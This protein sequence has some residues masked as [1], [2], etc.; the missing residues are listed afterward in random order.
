MYFTTIYSNGMS[1][2]F[3]YITVGPEGWY[4]IVVSGSE[5]GVGSG[6]DDIIVWRNSNTTGITNLGT[7]KTA[8]FS[9][10]NNTVS[11]SI[12]AYFYAADLIQINSKYAT[13][14]ATALLNTYVTVYFVST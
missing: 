12:M 14:G 1:S 5:G 2:T 13:T 8:G 11:Y 6:A 3:N 7:G 9:S 4:N 10:N